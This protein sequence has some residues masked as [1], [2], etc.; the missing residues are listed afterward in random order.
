MKKNYFIFYFNKKKF[1]LLL[2]QTNY[3]N[4]KL[5]LFL[6]KHIK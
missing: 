3:L 1:T 2:Y 6:S 5:K 4:Y